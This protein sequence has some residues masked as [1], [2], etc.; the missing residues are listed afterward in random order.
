MNT[1]SRI[2]HSEIK[3]YE[4]LPESRVFEV[5]KYGRHCA[6]KNTKNHS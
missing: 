2:I 4:F 6:T 1:Q 3:F 5:K